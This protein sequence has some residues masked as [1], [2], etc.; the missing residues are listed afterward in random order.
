MLSNGSKCGSKFSRICVFC[1]SSGGKKEVYKQTAEKLGEALVARGITLVY[2]GGNVGLMGTIASIVQENLG[3]DGVIGVIP[4]ALQP[5]EVC[6]KLI[7]RTEVV[8]DMHTRKARMAELSDGFIAMPGGFGTL[9][10]LMEMLTWHTLGFHKKPV[11]ILNVDGYYD[12]LLQF[13]NHIKDEGF[14]NN[15]LQQVVLTSD[16]PNTLLDMMEQYKAPPGQIELAK[17]RSAF[18]YPTQNEEDNGL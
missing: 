13:I 17:S 15:D 9:E 12:K 2:G 16:D 6:G 18:W 4:Q 1:G 7:G 14:I 8:E 5:K 3:D 11:A 10:E